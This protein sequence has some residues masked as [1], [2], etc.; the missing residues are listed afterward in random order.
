M[1]GSEKIEPLNRC[2]GEMNQMNLM[3]TFCKH[4]LQAQMLL[5][6]EAAVVVS[7]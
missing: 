1:I 3:N 6:A 2:E 7:P 5:W 4:N